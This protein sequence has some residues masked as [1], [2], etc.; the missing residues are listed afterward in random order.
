MRHFKLNFVLCLAVESRACVF[1][2]GRQ[3]VHEYRRHCIQN[4]QPFIAVTLQGKQRMS[5]RKCLHRNEAVADNSH[6][7]QLPGRQLANQ[8]KCTVWCFNYFIFVT[9][10]FSVHPC[11]SHYSHLLTYILTLIYLSF[12]PSFIYS[13]FFSSIHDTFDSTLLQSVWFI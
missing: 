3:A 7:S 5:H 11:I 1:A 10:C 4:A 12:C 8:S 9:H 2:R 6:I 13:F